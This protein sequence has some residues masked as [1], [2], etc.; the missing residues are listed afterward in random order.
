MLKISYQK[1][2]QFVTAKDVLESILSLSQNVHAAFNRVFVAQT[3]VF[4]GFLKRR[5]GLLVKRIGLT[6]DEVLFQAFDG[7]EKFRVGCNIF[8]LEIE[9]LLAKVAAN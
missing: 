7:V 1:T 6:V 8:T 9:K 3:D 4:D 2:E 5:D